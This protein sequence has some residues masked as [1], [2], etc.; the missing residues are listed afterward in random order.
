MNNVPVDAVCFGNHECDVPYEA[1]VDRINEF[2][3]IW[4]N[5][6]MPTFTPRTPAHHLIELEGGRS[7]ALIG[8]NI[9]GGANAALYR[10]GAFNGHANRIVPVLEAVDG[11]VAAA[12]D[13]Y[14]HADCVVPLT[15]QDLA[16]DIAMT[17]MGHGFPVV[18]GG[19]DHEEYT[20]RANGSVIVK[21]GID[22]EKVVVIDLIWAAGSP[23]GVPPT[24]VIVSYERL[25]TG[26]GGVGAASTFV[27]DPA[28]VKRMQ[29]W[30]QPIDE[31]KVATLHRGIP[32][33][34]T[35]S[36]V[37]VRTGRCTMAT[38]L[39]SCLRKASGVDAA[40]INAGSVRGDRVYDTGDVTYGDLTKECPFPSQ[41]LV[42]ELDGSTL[43]AAIEYSHRPWRSVPPTA[44]ADALHTDDMLA[45]NAEQDIVAVGGRAFTKTEMYEVLIDAYIIS[46]NPVLVAY[47]ESHP[48]RIPPL[49]SGM[50][51]LP[52]LVQFFIEQIWVML[53]TDCTPSS[54]PGSMGSLEPARSSSDYV[55]SFF[56]RFDSSNDDHV[57]VDELRDAIIG[58]LGPSFASHVVISQCMVAVDS[59]GDGLIG[60]AELKSYLFRK[61][62]KVPIQAHELLP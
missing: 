3:G 14:P 17:A 4:L 25:A 34:P 6:N 16:D 33:R 19:H 22:A 51:P 35:L 59:T 21:A 27:P 30:M 28:A 56:A 11:A 15:H 5:S 46:S 60:R 13:A 39:M 52:L 43:A 38:F 18:L 47:A 44:D 2:N 50:A 53:L 10:K 24:E 40:L 12:R 31:L 29:R 48:E 49:D 20:E 26:G 36:S 8:L 37:G 41:M 45:F 58:T 42:V 1:L 57:S 55:R 32:G 54:R 61:R 9:G 7:V 23:K 62:T